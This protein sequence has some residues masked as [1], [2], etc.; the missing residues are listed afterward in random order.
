MDAVGGYA[1]IM[2]GK[3]TLNLDHVDIVRGGKTL[4]VDL[5]LSLNQPQLLWIEGG[6]GIGK[7]SLLRTCAGLTRPASGTLTWLIDGEICTPPDCVG[8]LPAE[9]YAKSGLSAQEDAALWSANLDG[10]DLHPHADTRTERLSTGQAK[11]LSLAKLM[12]YDKPIWI[13][14]EPLAGLDAAGREAIAEHLKAHVSNGGIALV[15]SH[16]S[17][18][19]KDVFT[20][21]LTL[22]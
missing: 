5:S 8:F 18:P 1:P 11:R 22:R 10:V 17:I 19:I 16:A 6:N 13:L 21:R 7:T 14:D 15:A 20:Q 12:A 3:P 2:Y 9:S 4:I